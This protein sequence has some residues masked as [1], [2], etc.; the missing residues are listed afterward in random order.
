[1]CPYT[2]GGSYGSASIDG[3]VDADYVSNSKGKEV[4]K[5]E[6]ETKITRKKGRNEDSD[7]HK[8]VRGVEGSKLS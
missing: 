2:P 1:M 8:W 4:Q 5:A 6:Q 3:L 7:D